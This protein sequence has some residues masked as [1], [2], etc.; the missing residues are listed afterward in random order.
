MRT[1][2]MRNASEAPIPWECTLVVLLRIS[3]DM[4]VAASRIANKRQLLSDAGPD[5]LI[6]AACPDQYSQD[7]FVVDNVDDARAALGIDLQINKTLQGAPSG[8]Q[9]RHDKGSRGDLGQWLDQ[10]RR[11]L[12]R[13]FAWCGH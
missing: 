13:P 6:L 3:G 10:F 9:A 5:D 2:G 11:G 7:I 4:V 12:R 1:E 8:H